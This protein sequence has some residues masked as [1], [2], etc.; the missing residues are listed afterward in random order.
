MKL[1]HDN[2]L[3]E[4]I[5]VERKSKGGIFLGDDSEIE[6]GIGIVTQISDKIKHVKVGDKIKYNTQSARSLE[7]NGK[8]V[9]FVRESQDLILVFN[10]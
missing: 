10:D 2:I 9:V 4:P 3:V 6:K 8:D 1:L 5:K 7:L